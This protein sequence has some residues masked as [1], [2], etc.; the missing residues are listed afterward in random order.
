MLDERMTELE[1]ARDWEGMQARM[2]QANADELASEDG[3]F[4]RVTM[5]MMADEFDQ[6]EALLTEGLDAFPDSSRL[7]LLESGLMLR[8]F[9]DVG[10]V[11]AM[12]Q[13]RRIRRGLERAVELDPES[14]TARTGLIQYYLNAPRV[15]GGGAS[16][17]EPHLEALKV[18][19]LPDYYAMRATQSAVDDAWDDAVSWMMHAFN[20]DPTDARAVSL[21][22]TL[23]GAK[24]YDEARERFAAVVA[25]SPRHGGAWYQL[26]RLS[27]LA[28]DWLDEGR[29]AFE[30]FLSLPPWPNDPS[31]A[32][33]WWRLGQ[34]EM[35]ADSPAMA[36]AAFEQSLVMDPEFSLAEQALAE[37]EE[38]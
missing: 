24:R 36:R 26:G 8:G 27:V 34:I 32:A 2:A 11:G 12:R 17:A 23:L 33:A 31:P 9:S 38:S 4:W 14:V 1:Q 30:T 20:E 16:R 10:A 21:G 15:A 5:A 22:N 7:V 29:A 18:K 37:L 28:E 35:L 13:A 6:G 19:S 25:E 3:W